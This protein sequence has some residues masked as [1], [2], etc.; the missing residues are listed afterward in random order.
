MIA[1]P[2][3]PDILHHLPRD[4]WTWFAWYSTSLAL[5]SL[6]LIHLIPCATYPAI[7]E[8]DRPILA[9]GSLN[10]VR[11]IPRITCPAISEPGSLDILCWLSRNP[12]TWF[13]WYLVS[14]VLWSLNL[15]R[16]ICCII[17]SVISEP[18]SPDTLCR[19]SCDSW[20]WFTWYLPQDLWTWFIWYPAS[21]ALRS[22]CRLS[23]YLWIWFVWDPASLFLR[24]SN[25]ILLIFCIVCPAILELGS[26]DI[27][28]RI[29]ESDSFN[30]L[31]HLSHD[32][33]IWFVWYLSQDL[34]IWLAWYRTSLALRSSNLVRV[35]SYITCPAILEPGSP[36]ILCRLSQNLWIW[37]V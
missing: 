26:L 18:D 25:L 13:T 30:I 22:L 1:E 20:T 24:S 8:P 5:R 32:L 14:F 2:G 33:W 16:L 34:W 3:S 4:P 27:C 36:D 19:L 23:H 15:V 6:N 21:Y 9:S 31:C 12:W 37:F 28:L 11:L 17:C 35:I 7:P 29:S 10:L